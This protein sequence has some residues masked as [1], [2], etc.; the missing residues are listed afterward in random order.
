MEDDRGPLRELETPSEVSHG[1]FLVTPPSHS[2]SRAVK[3]K[4]LIYSL[5]GA[6]QPLPF[7]ALYFDLTA[8]NT[9]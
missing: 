6:D 9:F 3:G 7:L 1:I 2:T 8:M 4:T 5:R